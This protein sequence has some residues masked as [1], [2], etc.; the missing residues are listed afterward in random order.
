MGLNAEEVMIEM[1]EDNSAIV[2]RVAAT[3][4]G[5]MIDQLIS[6]QDPRFMQFLGNLCVCAGRPIPLTQ[7]K[8]HPLTS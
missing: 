1:V 4:L 5:Y 8:P 2:S 6:Q 7:S 3:E